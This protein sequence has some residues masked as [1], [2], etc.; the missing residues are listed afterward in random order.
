MRISHQENNPHSREHPKAKLS[1]LVGTAVLAG[2]ELPIPCFPHPRT[3]GSCPRLLLAVAP[4][5]PGSAADPAG[6]IIQPQLVPWRAN[7]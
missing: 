2:A 3:G 5:A 6:G 7:Q 1:H 4:E